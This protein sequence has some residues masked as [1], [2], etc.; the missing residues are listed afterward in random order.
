MGGAIVDP[1]G[2]DS[3][4]AESGIDGEKVAQAADEEERAHEE[5]QG[6]G[7]LR[8]NQEA[9]KA[10]FL[11]AGGEA[12]SGGADDGGGS[13]ARGAQRGGETEQDASED[14]YAGGETEDAPIEPEANE[15]AVALGGEEGDQA[16][17]E[18]GGQAHA[19][20]G[21]EEGEKHALG[22]ELQ[23]DAR[24]GSAHGLADGDFALAGA[25]AG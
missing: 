5:D 9:A 15:H 3:I 1:D 16:A 10:E 21:A 17:A 19:H 18:Q 13:D 14:R 2:D 11:T 4:G 25:G 6:H 22:K 23:N 8:D 12:A 24:A 20:G 7:D